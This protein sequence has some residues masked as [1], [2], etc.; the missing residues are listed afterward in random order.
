MKKR[1]LTLGILAHVDAGKTTLSE[2]MLYETGAIRS[3]GRVDHGD[4]TLD[5][6]EIERDRGITIFSKQ[7]R[8]EI[9]GPGSRP[10]DGPGAGGNAGGGFGAGGNAGERPD[11]SGSAVRGPGAGGA[12]SVTL[13]D[14]PGHVDFSA[15]TERTLQ[16]LDCALLIVSGTD[17]VQGHTRTLWRLLR[18]YGI[19]VLVFVNK[20]DLSE[21]SRA[22]LTEELNRELDPGFVD[23]TEAGPRNAAWLEELAMCD[24]ALLESYTEEGALSDGEIRC[25][26]QRRHVFPVWFGS[27]LKDEGVKELLAGIARWTCAFGEAGAEAGSGVGAGAGGGAGGGVGAGAGAGAGSGVGTGAGVGASAG[28]GGEKQSGAHADTAASGMAGNFAARVYKVGRDSAGARLTYLKVLSGSLSV[29]ET[30]CYRSAGG[31][32]YTEKTDQIRLYSGDRFELSQRAEAGEVCAVTGLSATRPGMGLGEAH[33]ETQPVLVPVMTR[34]MILPPDQSAAAFYRKIKVLEEEDPALHITWDEK[35]REIRAQIMGNVQIEVLIR[36]IKERFGVT[37]GFGRE[38]ILYRETV[39]GASVG[40]GHFEPL[41]HYAEAQLLITPGER[42]SGVAVDSACSE[43]LLALNW[44]RLITT[45]L[46]EREHAGVLTGAPLTDVKITILAGRAHLKHTEGGDFRQATYRA[47][48]QGLMSA[49]NVLLEPFYRFH[50]DLPS[51]S[52][53]RAMTDLSAGFAEFG[54]P[55]MTP[56]GTRTRLSGRAPVSS[57]SD[58]AAEVQTYTKGSGTLTLVPDGYGPC[59]NPEEVIAE[60]AYDPE[61]DAENPSAS[62]FCAHGAGYLVP[63]DLVPEYAHCEITGRAAE[64]LNAAAEQYGGFSC[65]AELYGG[66][67]GDAEWYD[68]APD[69]MSGSADRRGRISGGVTDGA[70]RCGRITG[71]VSDG[72][73]RAVRMEDGREVKAFQAARRKK[74]DDGD[75][76][77]EDDPELS[78]IYAREFG[79]TR[80]GI[81]TDAEMRNRRGW[82]RRPVGSGG[83]TGSGNAGSGISGNGFGAGGSGSGTFS[84][85]GTGGA[86]G[87]LPGARGGGEHK[88]RKRTDEAVS[89]E[90]KDKHGNPIYPKKDE[91]PEYLIVDGYNIIFQWSELA[92]LARANID[93]ARGKLLDLLSNYQGYTGQKVTVV[94]DAYRTDRTPDARMKYDNMEVVFTRQNVTADA[95]IE[96]LVHEEIK[97]YRITVATSDGL[98]QLTVMRLGALR[99]SASMLAED[100]RR[101]SE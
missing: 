80:D 98:E 91:R 29:K 32:E 45:H 24:E 53:G 10:D 14:T 99:M 57:M 78:A 39:A 70:D 15:E 43:D 40:I 56:D 41:R 60:A 81:R 11:I 66:V 2:A 92:A 68:G 77:M 94:F 18:T 88:Y 27:A 48:R 7:A 31:T 75:P 16:V 17:G 87:G 52:V 58:Y 36:I 3:I 59:H 61:L 20:M 34:G 30:V 21:R 33:G 4:T 65:G 25:A 54:A 8:I 23:F 6:D 46:L 85:S 97:H 96:R 82:N 37:V 5:T 50:L 26:I 64:A 12:L 72:A 84:E 67:P 9:G 83:S 74:K 62:V 89:S 51:D 35:T 101:V 86:G 47:V 42:G 93:A 28:A 44:Q 100:L 13:L 22:D 38:R 73:E 79:M 95:Y 1:M 63:W 71:T 76:A 49:E 90:K 69:G 55:E 19:P